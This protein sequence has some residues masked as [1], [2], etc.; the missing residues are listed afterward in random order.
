MHAALQYQKHYF[1]HRQKMQWKRRKMSERDREKGKEE[2]ALNMEVEGHYG[3]ETTKGNCMGRMWFPYS[4]AWKHLIR[5]S[6]AEDSPP[7][8]RTFAF[9]VDHTCKSILHTCWTT[10]T[11]SAAHTDHQPFRTALNPFIFYKDQA[12][13]RWI[14]T[15]AGF[16]KIFL[17][18]KLN[19]LR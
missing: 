19:F 9:V 18:N 12:T 1:K 14:N 3:A 11:V 2:E 8:S 6:K 16:S 5:F 4:G 17:R 10:V 15:E 7:S 13:L